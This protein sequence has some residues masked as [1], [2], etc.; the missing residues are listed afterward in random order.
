MS[1][2]N[3]KTELAEALEAGL[4]DPRTFEQANKMYRNMFRSKPYQASEYMEMLMEEWNDLSDN[5]RKFCYI[6]PTIRFK[7]EF[8]VEYNPELLI[9]ELCN[10][11]GEGEEMMALYENVKHLSVFVDKETSFNLFQ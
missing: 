6:E 7:E 10:Y 5:E 8:G 1:N 3:F 11:K 4:K 9:C 2:P